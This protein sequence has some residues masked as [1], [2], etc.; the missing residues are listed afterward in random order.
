MTILYCTCGFL[1]DYY[2]I[3]RET[4]GANSS[5]RWSCASI[6]RKELY[7]IDCR[8]CWKASWFQCNEKNQNRNLWLSSNVNSTMKC[9]T[10]VSVWWHI[11]EYG[12]FW[13]SKSVCNCWIDLVNWEANRECTFSYTG[14]DG[15]SAR[16][17][18]ACTNNRLPH[19]RGIHFRKFYFIATALMDTIV[20]CFIPMG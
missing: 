20:P 17:S 14:L 3:D 19:T 15:F 7:W 10:H 16:S 11:Q 13:C 18:V 6:T 12:T 1:S 2:I 8:H 5:K 9:V 4:R